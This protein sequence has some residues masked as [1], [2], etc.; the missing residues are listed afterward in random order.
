MHDIIEYKNEYYPALQAEGFALQ[1]VMP[2][3]KRVLAGK[4]FGYDVGC[5][6]EEWA[7]PGAM[8]IDPNINPAHDAL[9]LPPIQAD[10]II[11]SHCLEHLDD[12]RAAIDHWYSKL[13][14]GGVLFLY[15]PHPEQ[16]YWATGNPKH[17][18]LMWPS[19]VALYLHQKGWIK[20]YATEKDLNYSF[21]VVAEKP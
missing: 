14:H 4:T 21:T 13:K 9:N 5:N 1:W 12:W 3:A 7:Y 15:L 17:K 20:V 11:S 19:K 6:R 2:F 8:A 16:S 18:H 10:Y